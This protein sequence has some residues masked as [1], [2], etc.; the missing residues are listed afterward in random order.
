MKADIFYDIILRLQINASFR[1][2][3][4]FVTLEDIVTDDSK[5]V[6]KGFIWRGFLLTVVKVLTNS[7]PL[8]NYKKT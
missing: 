3:L 5:S 4:S 2:D 6:R 1:V 8:L 7:Q